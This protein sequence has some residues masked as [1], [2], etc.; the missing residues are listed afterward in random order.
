MT[1][2]GLQRWRAGA[3]PGARPGDP[4]PRPG[5]GELIALAAVAVIF[6][7]LGWTSLVRESVTFDEFLHL[8][9][10]L[11]ILRTG[12]FRLEQ[13]NSPLIRLIMALPLLRPEV[14]L[15]LQEGWAARDS[16]IAGNDFMVA[17]AD[18]YQALVLPCRAMAMALGLG[19]I[20]VCWWWARG[21]YGPAAGLAAAVICAFDPNLMAYAR[22]ATMD[23]GAALTYLAA[24]LVFGAFCR[25]PTWPRT[26]AAGAM[27]GGAV[28]SKF[29]FAPPLLALPVLAVW[30]RERG[31]MPI[32]RRG[33][34]LR[35]LVIGLMVWF[36]ICS[37]YLW[38]GVG[39]SAGSYHFDHPGLQRRAGQLPSW[40]PLPLPAPYLAG[41][42]FTLGANTKYRMVYILGQWPDRVH[43]WYYLLAGAVKTPPATQMLLLLG[44]V[45]LARKKSR[46]GWNEA[47]LV[48]PPLLLFLLV[49]FTA[50]IGIRL[51]YVLPIYPFGFVLASRCFGP[52]WPQ[53]RWA[54]ILSVALL[55]GGIGSN[56]WIYPH[57]LAYFN[58]AAGGPSNGY[59]LLID[60]NLD[61]G[62]D[63]IGL[64]RYLDAEG[65]DHTCL[66]YFGKVDPRIYGINYTLG[67]QPEKCD[68]L[69]ISV[70]LVAG[71]RYRWVLD[72]QPI[73]SRPGKFRWL[74][75]QPPDRVIGHTIWVYRRRLTPPPEG[76]P[77]GELKPGGS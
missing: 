71:A 50:E 74:L 7:G 39:R 36:E 27:L 16:W 51:R 57:Y 33:L 55:A 63:L 60:S 66:L 20:I 12:D 52:A 46:G 41:L 29:I 53:R 8:P 28:L 15:P 25:R 42:D 72:G 1:A 49:A 44:L 38:R 24:V 10:G 48:L 62:Q 21:L 26:A 67:I 30:R 40:L 23:L 31:A 3:A 2:S 22:L 35:L 4:R 34:A 56:L 47:L 69:A 70:S 32:T 18:H 6:V 19:L 58:A 17:N 54:R 43:A 59:K 76:G 77:G 9:V 64:K 61:W 65:L 37:I 13:I 45:S 14:K 75:D 11:S 5:R 68:T 73:E